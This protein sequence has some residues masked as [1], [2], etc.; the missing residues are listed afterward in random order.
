M[1]SKD[2]YSILSKELAEAA[3]PPPSELSRL[4]DG[5]PF[6]RSIDPSGEP[7]EI[8]IHVPWH[9]PDRATVLISAHA[10]GSSTWHHQHCKESLVVAL[11]P[12]VQ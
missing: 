6:S 9:G 2:A 4:A 7:V 10:R 8:E 11:R 1:Q 12:D 3:M 5:A